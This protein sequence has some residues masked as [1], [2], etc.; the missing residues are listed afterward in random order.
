MSGVLGWIRSHLAVVVLT[1]ALP[2]TPS[3]SPT[4]Q[5]ATSASLSVTRVPPV[6]CA[7]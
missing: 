3:S 1:A 5:P 4:R 6:D 7:S 2:P